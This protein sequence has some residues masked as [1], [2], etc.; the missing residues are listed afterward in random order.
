MTS[1]NPSLQAPDVEI[2][3]DAYAER[4]SG[5]VGEWFLRV[6]EAATLRMLAPYPGASV[7]DVGGGHGQ[8]A[9]P[10]IE[11]GYDLTILGSSEACKTQVRDLVEKGR[12]RFDVGDVVELPYSENCFDVVISYRMVPHIRKWKKFLT[13]LSRVSR[14]AVVIDYPDTKSFNYFKKYF[15]EIKKYVEEGTR[16]YKCFSASTLLSKF[17]MSGM[18][19]SDHYRQF[20]WPMFLHRGIGS[21]RMSMLAEKVCRRLGLTSLWGSPVILRVVH[22]EP[23]GR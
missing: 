6:Q 10:L 23:E 11:N 20:F 16:R 2:A 1:G 3:S 14:K 8:T 9:T 22:S 4:F 13:E 15:F 12:C 7:L 19:Y 18:S 21:V 5:A 17:E